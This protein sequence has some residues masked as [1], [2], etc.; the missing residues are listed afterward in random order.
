MPGKP[1]F[2]E[3]Q[4]EPWIEL[5]MENLAWNLEEIRKH[6]K[7][8]PVTAVLK[9]NA[10]GHG[11]IEIAKILREYGV[12]HFA[13]A[14][15]RDTLRLREHEIDG[16]ILNLGVFTSPGTL[17]EML[18]F[19]NHLLGLEPLPPLTLKPVYSLKSRVLLTKKIPAGAEIGWNNEIKLKKNTLFAAVPVGYYDGYPPE[20]LGKA[21]VLIRGRRYP[22][23]GF[24]SA[25]HITIDI[26]GSTDIQIG[27]EVVMVGKQGNEEITNEELGKISGRGPCGLPARLNP[28]L[29]KLIKSPGSQTAFSEGFP[30]AGTESE[31]PGDYFAPWVELDMQNLAWNVTETRKRVGQIPILAV[32]KCNAYGHGL[33]EISKH[34]VKNGI[35][36]FAVVKPWEA[37]ALRKNNIHGT[38]LNL[39]SFSPLEAVDLVKHNISQSV[40]SDTVDVLAKE[41]RRQNKRAYVHI[42]IDTGLGRVGVPMEEAPDFIGKVAAMP[43]IK[44][45]GVFTVLTGIEK[46][47]GQL[48][49]FTAICDAAEKGGISMGFR[50]AAA[51]RDVADGPADAYLDMVRPGNCLYGLAPFA[52]MDLKPVLTLKSRVLRIKK[53][54]AGKVSAYV[55]VGSCDG[56]PPNKSG[57]VEV[58]IKGRRY[59][60]KRV[61]SSYHI[62]VDITGSKDIETGD[63]VVLLGRQ[64]DREI[65]N[66]ELS[67]RSGQS[68]YRTPVYLNP[69]IPRLIT[70]SS[71]VE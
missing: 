26:T 1:V 45:E 62:S 61:V 23:R 31:L 20:V 64:G 7:N 15:H 5:D 9:C 41:A 24:I 56:Y 49:H 33:V 10:Y 71:A 65:T 46:I 2:K 16:T 39:G 40:F 68:V 51:S 13:V 8:Q 28:A 25:D 19:G 47:P 30:I 42:K 27:D 53:T 44:I 48:K 36:H 57:K 67:G 43:E 37:L 3:D 21:D 60:L 17:P 29:P 50:H 70:D 66:V 4:F 12:D 6:E 14:R 34:L 59:P 32:V 38:I 35:R 18:R 63:E 69:Y 55:A 52:N 22:V 11:M 58:L 54:A